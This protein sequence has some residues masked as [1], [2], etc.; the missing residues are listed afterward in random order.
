MPAG[1][2]PKD[3]PS[4]GVTLVT[5]LISA[6]TDTPVCDDVCMTGEVTLR[7]RVLPVGGI[8]EKILAAVAHK[9]R[10]V[11]IPVQNKRDLEEVPKDLRARIKVRTVELID[12]IWP[13]ACDTPVPKAKPKKAPAKTKAKAKARPKA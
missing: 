5:A 9:M 8:K 3:G 7:G 12:E 6:L 13:L 2:T 11:I 1:A 10:Q 4:A